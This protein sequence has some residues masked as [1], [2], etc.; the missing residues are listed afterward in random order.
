MFKKVGIATALSAALLFG[1]TFSTNAEA[2]TNQDNQLNSSY[3]VYYSINGQWGTASGEDVQGILDKVMNRFDINWSEF[4]WNSFKV[5][6]QNNAQQNAKDEDKNKEENKAKEEVKQPQKEKPAEAEQPAKE[7]P[8]KEKPAEQ[9][10]PAAEKPAQEAPAK[11][12]QP[13]QPAAPAKQPAQ[14]EEQPAQNQQ[15]SEL[16]QFEQEVVELTNQERAKQGLAP[17][18]IDTELSK[19]AREKSNDMATNNYFDHNSPTYGSPFDMMKSFGISYSTAG[20]NIAQG[21]RT[22]EEVVNAW[23]NSEGHRANI[24]NG[25]YTHIGVGYVEQGNH[26]TQQF[27]GK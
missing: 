24:L 21:Q 20:E 25:D 6:K 12:E 22:P 9:E 11:E 14:Q 13:A 19:V 5:E 1:G 2:S 17:L 27:I 8:A 7:Q 23:M 10:K 15:Q 4:D 18:E 3:K 26:W 16:S